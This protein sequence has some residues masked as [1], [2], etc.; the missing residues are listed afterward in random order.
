MNATSCSLDALSNKL[1]RHSPLSDES[2]AKLRSLAVSEHSFL[3]NEEIIPQGRYLED[4]Y[5]IDKG[6][7]CRS[8]LLVDGTL[9]ILGFL[10]PGDNTD[11]NNALT[12]K[13]DH[14]IRAVTEVSAIR[15]KYHALKEVIGDSPSLARA[16]SIAKMAEEASQ[17]ALLIGIAHHAAHVRVSHFLCELTYRMHG[18]IENAVKIRRIPLTQVEL[19]SALG[20]SNVHINRVMRT[21]REQNLVAVGSGS[22][23]VLDWEGLADIGQFDSDYLDIHFSASEVSRNKKPLNAPTE[24]HQVMEG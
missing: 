14:S 10:L 1:R 6:W 12:P 21:F 24:L 2:V 16:F 18:I 15:V 20:L 7:A 8:T 19:G 23:T 17:R 5:I 9:C 22:V 3:R 4:I 11:L 13:T